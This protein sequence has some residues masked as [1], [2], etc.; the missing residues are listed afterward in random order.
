M[1]LQPIIGSHGSRSA[2]SKPTNKE[3]GNRRIH[4]RTI[5]GSWALTRCV[6]GHSYRH[7]RNGLHRV[8]GFPPS[9]ATLLGL[10]LLSFLRGD[11]L[12]TRSVFEALSQKPKHQQ[13]YVIVI[14]ALQD[15]NFHVLL[16]IIDSIRFYLVAGEIRMKV[17]FSTSSVQLFY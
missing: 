12:F 13:K 5:F 15:S 6:N 3:R 16:M 9:T 2:L 1:E 7:R 11:S 10:S 17:S 14:I 4:G 8:Q